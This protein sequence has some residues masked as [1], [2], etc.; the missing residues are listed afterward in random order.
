MR[1]IAFLSLSSHQSTAIST[2]FNV[3]AVIEAKAATGGFLL[4]WLIITI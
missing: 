2:I 4:V 1:K 3:N